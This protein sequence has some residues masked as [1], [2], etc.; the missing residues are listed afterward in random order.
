VSTFLGIII[1]LTAMLTG[2]PSKPTHAQ[3]DC[4]A[5]AITRP[6]T[7]T[8]RM[9]Q[10]FTSPSVRSAKSGRMPDFFSSR[11][12]GANKGFLDPGFSSASGRKGL[13]RD[14]DEFSSA[15]RSSGNRFRDMDE[16]S[17]RSRQSRFRDFDEFTR[18]G[19]RQRGQ[20]VQGSP[21][22]AS[23]GFHRRARRVTSQDSRS[24]RGR[25]NRND[26]T[27]FS[28]SVNP[29]AGEKQHREPQMG[30][31]GGSVGKK[32]RDSKRKMT[33]LPDNDSK[34]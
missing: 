27:P 12:Q 29:G 15:G 20:S 21:G 26:Y 32:G 18:K 7:S 5:M 28:N 16:F 6:K 19:A 9:L 25:A 30:L 24:A 13:F 14:I 3:V 22:K 11:G 8:K 33:P 1:L 17:T 34:E 31:W 23:K 10:G 2:M 4:P